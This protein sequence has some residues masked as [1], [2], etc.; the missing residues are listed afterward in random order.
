[1]RLGKQRLT[2]LLMTGAM[3]G[4]KGYRGG[5]ESDWEWHVEKDLERL[6]LEEEKNGVWKSSAKKADEWY[7]K[8]EGGV[9]RF[10]ERWHREET[11]KS[12]QRRLARADAEQAARTG[13][14]RRRT[15]GGVPGIRE[16]KA[17]LE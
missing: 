7:A 5:Q 15:G 16:K 9:E 3:E 8:V 1:M 6:G 14:K 2:N 4:G 11:E 10:M 12:R 17:K 13:P